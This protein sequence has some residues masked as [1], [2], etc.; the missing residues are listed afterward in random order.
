MDRQTNTNT[1]QPIIQDCQLIL[2]KQLI[3]HKHKPSNNLTGIDT[4][5]KSNVFSRS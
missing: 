2:S 3:R 1:Y 4:A 5:K